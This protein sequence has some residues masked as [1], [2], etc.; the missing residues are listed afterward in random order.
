MKDGMIGVGIVG[1]GFRGGGNLGRRMA[2]VSAETGLRV[3][4]L[5]D[6]RRDRLEEVQADLGSAFSERGV[7]VSPRGYTDA[8]DLV[9][10]PDLDLL[11]VTT[12]QYA[13]RPPTLAGLDAGKKVYVEKPLAHDLADARAIYEAMVQHRSPILM[14]FTRRYEAPWRMAFDLVR[15]GIIGELH[16][17]LLRDV[18]PFH[19]FFHRWHRRTKWSG[20]A[21]NDK[22]SHHFDVMNWF[23]GSRAQTLSALG[24]R[25][26]FHPD[27]S[28]PARCLEC[29]RDCPYR[30]GP[31][32]GRKLSQEQMRI[33]GDSWTRATDEIHRVDNC[34][35]L[36]GA[37]S[38][39]HAIMQVGFRNGV[40]GSLFVSF[41]GP[42]S[43]DQETMELVG[44]KGRIHL[45]RH[46]GELDVLS[47]YGRKHETIDCRCEEFASSHFGADLEL[48][49]EMVRFAAGAPPVV[50]V[51]E[52][53]EATRM[54]MATHASIAA[55][56]T[57][58]DMTAFEGAD[59]P[60]RL[61]D[62]WPPPNPSAP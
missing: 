42:R 24:G 51:P 16:M 33:E 22:S 49:R 38:K 50:S 21:L 7:T 55:G 62:L 5:C 34:V 32:R 35:F 15:N 36:P 39:D 44:T 56:G 53:F 20:G 26:V 43:E 47:E 8:A 52:G 57:T 11:V 60:A 41:F 28:A 30:V 10:D 1:V 61:Q 2:E 48:V 54:V 31:T 37:D 12:P 29:D 19:T 13:H 25:R 46:R 18:I 45:N 23:A 4:A 9:T 58:I 3:V 40:V 17:I 14:G 59:L 27:P 6:E